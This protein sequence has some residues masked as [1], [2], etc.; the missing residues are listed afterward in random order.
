MHIPDGFLS[1]EVC[2]ATAGAAVG[3]VGYSLHRIK[4]ELADRTIPLTGMMGSLI[5]A[6]QMINFPI[7]L[8]VSGHLMGGVLAGAILG[9]WAGC[10]ALTMVLTAQ[11]ALFSDGGLTALGANILH[12]GVLGSIGG[13]AVMAAV[14]RQFKCRKRGT[15]IG[16]VIA[17]WLSV[18]AAAA[19]FCVE[20]RLSHAPGEFRF[21]NIFTLMVSFH[22]LIG[23]GEALITAVVVNVVLNHRPDLVFGLKAEEMQSRP[24]PQFLGA[25]LIAALAV[26]AFA[27]PFASEFSDGLEAVAE[28]ETIAASEEGVAGMFADYDAIPLGDWQ[29]LSVSAAGIVGVVAIFALSLIMARGLSRQPTRQLAGATSRE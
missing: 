11:W 20:F 29:S 1:N 18:M 14:R 22:A 19:L 13:Y 23:I 4:G 10:I 6:G 27:S 7:G 15:V 21:R 17:A 26:A 5:F 9:P 3:A 2:L 12:M 8:P 25:G 28:R 24:L 16:S